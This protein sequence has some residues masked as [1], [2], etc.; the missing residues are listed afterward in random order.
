M[1][2]RLSG[3]HNGKVKVDVISFNPLINMADVQQ[4]TRTERH[5]RAFKIWKHPTGM[6][7]MTNGEEEKNHCGLSSQ[8]FILWHLF[9]FH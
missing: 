9:V 2:K 5:Q 6:W 7:D 8:H 4:T 1:N 3:L